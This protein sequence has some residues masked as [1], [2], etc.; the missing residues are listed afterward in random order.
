MATERNPHISDAQL[1][2]AV[3]ALGVLANDVHVDDKVRLQAA[4][5]LLDSSYVYDRPAPTADDVPQDEPEVTFGRRLVQVEPVEAMRAPGASP[6]QTSPS[7][8]L[9]T[10]IKL[11]EG[12]APWQV[13]AE[14]AEHFGDA[15]LEARLGPW[16]G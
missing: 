9:A 6:S 5:T 8:T 13:L 2:S 15:V 10:T 14:L 4:T 12:Q 3:A 7:Q 1:E 16:Y 11:R